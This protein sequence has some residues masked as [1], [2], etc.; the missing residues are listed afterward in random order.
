MPV[1]DAKQTV[2]IMI[3]NRRSEHGRPP[4]K[5]PR[6]AHRYP[7]TI[8]SKLSSIRFGRRTAKVSDLSH[9]GCR[10]WLVATLPVGDTVIMTL[11]T[12]APLPARIIWSDGVSSGLLFVRPL[13]ASVFGMMA[14]RHGRSGQI[15]I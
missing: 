13:S 1:F 14:E 11:P 12:L 7:V 10:V 4:S 6:D 5:T 15:A 2:A 9:V 3:S 8:T